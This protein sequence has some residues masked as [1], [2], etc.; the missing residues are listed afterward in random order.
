MNSAGMDFQR[1]R[2]EALREYLQG[3]KCP[4]RLRLEGPGA[5][6]PEGW[7]LGPKAEN[8]HI[9]T[10][11]ITN[12]IG[13]HCRYRLQFQPED[14]AYITEQIKQ[15]PD[16]QK[17][18]DNLNRHA[19]ELFECLQLSAPIFS[20]RHQGHMLWDQ[21]L[22]AIVGYFAAMLYNQN[23][24]A[25]EASPVTTL[26]EIEVG[27]DLCRMLGFPVPPAGAPN[28]PGVPVP[29]GHITCGG[30]VANI[31]ALWAAR[32]AKFFPVALRAALRE[33]PDLAAARELQVKL[34]DGRKARL[35][36]LD[37]WVLLNLDIDEVVSLPQTMAGEPFKIPVDITTGALHSYSLQNIGFVDFYQ[38]FMADVPHAPVV[39]VPATRHYSWP[40]A[41]TLLGFGQN[42]ILSVRVDLQA[43]MDVTHL[44]GMLQ[45]CL[46]KRIPVTAVV[47]VIGSTEES[48]VDPLR[49]MLDVREQFRRKGL[50]FAV[51]CDAAWG[52]YFNSMLRTPEGMFEVAAVPEYPMSGYV[53]E[54]YGALGDADS[55]TVDPHKAGYVPYPAGSVCYRNSAMRDLISLR[56]PVVF[57]SKAEE[58]VGVYG[59]EGSKPGA[60]AAAVWLAHK[61]IRPDRNGYGKLL[62]QCMWTSKRMYCRLVT[63]AKQ[64]DRFTITFFQML[65][66]E[67]EQRSEAEIDREKDYIRNT[68]LTPN[69]E[70]L[71]ALL[72]KPGTARDLF[73]QLGSD[74]VILA[75]SF[76]FVS[77][78]GRPNTDAT[79]MN[80]L[81]KKVFEICSITRLVPELNSKR[82]IITSSD[83]GPGAYGQPFVDHYSRRCGVTPVEG[84]PIDFLIS[85]TM[86]P[87]TT[88][89]S[90]PYPSAP[91]GFLVE[92]ENALRAAVQEALKELKY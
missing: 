8:E 54:Q 17:A 78:D 22:P 33:V 40:K 83:F 74:Q 11:L 84:L 47:A 64:G 48:A 53:V 85:T 38:R 23:N 57:H 32:N 73:M 65:P 44:E 24:V 3:S 39:M 36:D 70:D 61:V 51:H 13:A 1:N 67:R 59:V 9:L 6:R 12:A 28:Q 49:K 82:L 69:N 18:V 5:G 46:Q 88:D 72:E 75:Y 63:M 62:G 79:R 91:G 16:Y 76:N 68:F 26:L 66:S 80:A 90:Y 30:S 56:A 43:R 42:N 87:W 55:I 71:K 10:R 29:W 77:K 58:T 14:P 20:M 19:A 2:L 92:V 89:A 27:N 31:E 21:A 41:G 50:N 25:A 37:T 86:D 81:N 35:T 34:P 15:H 4:D 7:F 60:A 45:T 52:G